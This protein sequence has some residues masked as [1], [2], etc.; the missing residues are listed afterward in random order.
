MIEKDKIGRRRLKD[1]TV[2]VNVVFLIYLFLQ[3]PY[4]SFTKENTQERTNFLELIMNMSSNN[5]LSLLILFS[6]LLSFILDSA[7]LTD[8]CPTHCG[9]I[10]ILYPFGV[11]KG[12]YLEKWYEIT[13][14]TSTSGKVV[15]FLSVINKEVVDI[16]L[17][18]QPQYDVDLQFYAS[19]RIKIPITSKGCSNDREELGSLLDLTGTPFYVSQSNK[20]IAV[21][22]NIT[23]LLTNVT[24]CNGNGC[25]TTNLPSGANLQTVDVRIDNTTTTEGCKVA[26]LTDETYFLSNV[27]D[28]QRLQAKRYSTVE[29]Q[30]FIHTA[31]GSFVKSLGCYNMKEY[32]KL[33]DGD[34]RKKRCVCDYNDYLSYARC[35]CSRGYKGNPYSLGGCEG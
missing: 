15:P 18:Y 7:A 19:I 28:P 2:Q 21:G 16:S 24:S 20:L 13:C 29:L 23:A 30:W 22:C 34:R 4:A 31:N 33:E 26:F 27:S 9:G 32:V 5:S 6:L 17:P 12:C 35:S 11:G 10:K 1:L 25:C 8:S 14:K 3:K